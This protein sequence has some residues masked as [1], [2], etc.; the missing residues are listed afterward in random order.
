MCH[1]FDIKSSF[2]EKL[3]KYDEDTTNRAKAKGCPFCKGILDRANYPRKPRCL[4][5]EL[6]EPF[7]IRLSLCCRSEGCRKRVTPPSVRFFGRRVYWSLF[8]LL[9]SVQILNLDLSNTFRKTLRR[10][11]AWWNGDFFETAGWRSIQGLHLIKDEDD[12]PFVLTKSSSTHD[13]TTIMLLLSRLSP[14]FP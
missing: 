1:L 3:L 4:I 11:M 10:W 6:P 5:V 12:S 14:C 2:Y 9:A 7:S 8:F 13:P